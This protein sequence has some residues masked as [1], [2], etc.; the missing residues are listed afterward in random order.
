M[1][2]IRLAVSHRWDLTIDEA[3]CLQAE[4]A[5]RVIA[6]TAFDPNQVQKVA[7]I[8]VGFQ[9]G[10]ARA[11]VVVLSFPELEMLDFALGECPASFPYIPGL[12]T[13]REGPSILA[14]LEKLTVP[15][16]L[17]IFDGQG[18]AHPRRIGLASHLGVILDRPS[19]GCAKSRL[20]GEHGELGDEVGLWVPL[21][22]GE[23]IIGAVVRSR[24]KVKPL[25]VSIGHRVDLPTA[26]DIVL[27]CTTRYRLPE[28]TRQ[29]HRVAAGAKP[30]LGRQ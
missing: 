20:A 6:E 21:R 5:E 25:Y 2:T 27:R 12:L 18:I 26:V 7:G 16:D 11:A 19:I 23:E 9:A 13:F 8:D 22:D 24:A 4:M 15:P 1:G 3:R 30:T 28:T 29:A 17:L 10:R 14:A